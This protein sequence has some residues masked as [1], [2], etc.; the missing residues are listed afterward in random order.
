MKPKV[1]RSIRLGATQ[2]GRPPLVPLPISEEELA[3]R[4]AMSDAG[5]TTARRRKRKKKETT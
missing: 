5:K 1:K 3:T 2:P 4:K